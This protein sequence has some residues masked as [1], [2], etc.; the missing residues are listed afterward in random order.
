MMMTRTKRKTTT[1]KTR[2][3]TTNRRSCASRT[4]SKQDACGRRI[5]IAGFGGR[6]PQRTCDALTASGGFRGPFEIP[7]APARPR[8][9]GGFRSNSRRSL[10]QET[11]M[12]L[13]WLGVLLVFGGMIQL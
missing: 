5:G 10:V 7:G 13:I 6:D 1:A 4:K 2:T 3:E 12:T 8:M 9:D 11:S